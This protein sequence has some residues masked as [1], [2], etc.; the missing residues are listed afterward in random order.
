MALSCLV[1]IYISTLIHMFCITMASLV[2]CTHLLAPNVSDTEALR[3]IVKDESTVERFQTSHLLILHEDTVK[4]FW[5]D[6]R[7]LNRQPGAVHT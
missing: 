2:A 3:S 6:P 1:Q 4:F 7:V 5:E